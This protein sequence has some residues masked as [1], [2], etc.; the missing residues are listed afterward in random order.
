VTAIDALI[1]AAAEAGIFCDFDGCLA[2][3][4]PEPEDAQPLPGAVDALE[5]LAKRFRVVAIVSGRSVADLL[6]RVQANGVW[7]IGLHGMEEL[8]DDR[9]W[10]APEA[11]AARGSIEQAARQLDE[12]LRGIPGVVLER[13]GL[14]LAVHFRRAE[15]PAEAELKATPAVLAVADATGL[16]VM[17]GRRILEVRPRAGGDKG[18][19][20]RRIITSEGIVAALVGGDDV[21]DIPAF[22]AVTGLRETLRVAVVSRE[23]PPGLAERADMVLESPS[24]F[25]DLLRRLSED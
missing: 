7:L 21:G 23:S 17:P 15:D 24:A 22:D 20:L 8:R 10:T 19:A 3:V 2:P 14:A 1:D 12:H 4:V 6:R 13:K 25:V 5:R 16:A 11:E 9:I 18:D